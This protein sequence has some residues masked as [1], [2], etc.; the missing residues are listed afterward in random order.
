MN[1][2]LTL[3]SCAIALALMENQLCAMNGGRVLAIANNSTIKAINNTV[4]WIFP[5]GVDISYKTN[6]GKQ[7]TLRQELLKVPKQ[8]LVD[9]GLSLLQFAELQASCYISPE[10]CG[11]GEG[12]NIITSGIGVPLAVYTCW[13]LSQAIRYGICTT[14]E[15]DSYVKKNQ[16]F[17]GIDP[18]EKLMLGKDEKLIIK[19]LILANKQ[20][21]SYQKYSEL[22]KKIPSSFH[23]GPE[24]IIWFIQ[25]LKGPTC[26]N[27][28][29]T[30]EVL[31]QEVQNIILGYVLGV[32]YQ[33]LGNCYKQ[34][35]QKGQEYQVLLKKVRKQTSVVTKIVAAQLIQNVRKLMHGNES[36][37]CGLTREFG[38]VDPLFVFTIGGKKTEISG[39]LAKSVID[40]YMTD[41]F[42]NQHVELSPNAT[43]EY[44]DKRFYCD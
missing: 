19:K 12:L 7:V 16:L 20:C 3:F 34:K 2:V 22:I 18:Q 4:E 32:S 36:F 25:N 1:K 42:G 15:K 11:Q 28:I 35:E 23:M 5:S 6:K 41:M 40:Y 14:A 38:I 9:L 44:E 30:Y 10:M 24:K 13:K 37:S 39:Q 29:I 17:P 21:I 33:Q 8:E 27:K 31:P 43:V 26:R